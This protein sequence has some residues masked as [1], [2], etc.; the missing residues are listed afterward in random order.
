MP[1]VFAAADVVTTPSLYLDA[2]NLMNIEAMA[3][4]RPVVGTCF[5]GTTEIIENNVTG[6]IVDPTDAK[7]YASALTTLLQDTDRRKRMGM[8]GKKRVE[9]N[10]SLDTFVDRHLAAYS[11]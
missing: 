5:G 11:R 4:E 1:A 3:M 10:Y 6:I 8:A 9:E 2:F 7:T